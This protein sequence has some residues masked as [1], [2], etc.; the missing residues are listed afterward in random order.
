MSDRWR[1]WS[2]CVD[3]YVRPLIRKGRPVKFSRGLTGGVNT[4]PLAVVVEFCYSQRFEHLKYRTVMGSIK[5]GGIT[6]Q[7]SKF[8]LLTEDFGCMEM[9]NKTC[10]K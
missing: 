1:Q 6:G 2:D 8:W 5:A 9:V 10:K 3:V 7:L 4:I